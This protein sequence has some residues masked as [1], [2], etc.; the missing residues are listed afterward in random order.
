[1]QLSSMAL[2]GPRFAKPSCWVVSQQKNQFCNLTPQNTFIW[3]NLF[4]LLLC[5]SDKLQLLSAEHGTERNLSGVRIP[6][7]KSN[8][9]SMIFFGK[10]HFPAHVKYLSNFSVLSISTDRME[11]QVDFFRTQKFNGR[12]HLSLRIVI[13]TFFGVLFLFMWNCANE[14]LREKTCKISAL[15]YSFSARINF[16]PEAR[17]VFLCGSF[18]SELLTGGLVNRLFSKPGSSQSF[19]IF[20]LY[21]SRSFCRISDYSWSIS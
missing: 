17:S 20:S 12:F 4:F 21:F 2:I 14:T 10:H 8:I 15:L 1:M 11:I 7:N 19:C 3:W 5:A 9:I 18:W 13:R 16:F 6:I